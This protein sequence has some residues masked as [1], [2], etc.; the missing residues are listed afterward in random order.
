MTVTDERMKAFQGLLHDTEGID[1]EPSAA[2]GFA[3]PWRILGDETYRAA[4]GLDDARM[5]N[6]THIVW[7]TGGSMVPAA[8]MAGYVAE[9]Q[10]LAGEVA[11]R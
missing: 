8:E 3:G 9:G 2:A 1:I 4:F 6:A 10:R 7:S 5:A 11:W